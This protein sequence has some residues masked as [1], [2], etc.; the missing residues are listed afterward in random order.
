MKKVFSTGL[1]GFKRVEWACLVIPMAVLVILVFVQIVMRAFAMKGFPWLEE[2]SRY[3]FVF[4]TFLGAS[5]AIDTDSHP[6]MTA[7]LVAVPR[8]VRLL[9]LIVGNAFCCAAC[10]YIAY[11]GGEQIM[12]QAASGAMSTALPIPMYVPYIMI[13]LG[14]FTSGIRYA[15]LVVREIKNLATGADLKTAAEGGETA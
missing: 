14:L 4:A 3:V 10:F 12:R 8:K 2:F 7:V 9:L 5:V 13:P 11:Y 15:S 6:K 1:K